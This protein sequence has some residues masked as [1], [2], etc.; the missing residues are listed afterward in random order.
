[1]IWFLFPKIQLEKSFIYLLCR[2]LQSIYL[3]CIAHC[4]MWKHLLK[5]SSKTTAGFKERTRTYLQPQVTT[6]GF[7]AL[8]TFQV[9]NTK[10]QTFPAL[11]CRNGSYRYVWA[12]F[13]VD[14]EGR[15]SVRIDD[16]V[17]PNILLSLQQRKPRRGCR[18][19][20]GHNRHGEFRVNHTYHTSDA[21]GAPTE[22]S[23]DTSPFNKEKV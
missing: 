21:K 1:M 20:W 12:G 4:L 18:G 13:I 14:A 7:S 15:Q 22:A 11:H 23:E 16:V 19:W 9:D 2:I 8:F 3:H 17:K 6:M 5:I 10:S